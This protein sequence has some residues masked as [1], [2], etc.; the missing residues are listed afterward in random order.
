[1]GLFDRIAEKIKSHDPAEHRTE[2][3]S[4]PQ[5][6]WTGGELVLAPSS[7]TAEECFY[8]DGEYRIAFRVNDSFKP[9]KS[10]AGEVEMPHTYA[11]HDEYG[12]E[13]AYPYLAVQCDDAVYGAVEAYKEGGT[14]PGALELTPLS[15][16]LAGFHDAAERVKFYFRAKIEY[17]GSLM[18][19]YGMDLCGGTLEN[20]GLCMVYPK[21]LAGTEAE[22]RLM[23]VLDEAAETCTEERMA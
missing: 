21:V 22:R 20:Q 16:T 19:F 23:S 15:G 2:E 7:H 6:P 18:Y 3:T 4:S 17:Y 13:G 14:V 5:T 11:P 1:M 12:V 9:A 10:H 8:G